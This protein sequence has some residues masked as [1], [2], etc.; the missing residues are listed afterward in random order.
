MTDDLLLEVEEKMAKAVDALRHDLLI[1]RTGRASP[2]LVEDLKVEAY[3]SVMPLNQL[4]T[5]A[6]PE[7]RL[8]VIRPWDASTLSAIERA[9]LKSDLGLT[10]NND[11]KVIRL[12]IPP[13]T[14]ERRKDLAR[15]VNQRVEE[16]RV[17]VRNARRD[18]MRALQAMER[19]GDISEDDRYRAQND[20]QEVTD[21]YIGKL[22]ALGEAKQKEIMEV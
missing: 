21:E 5:I 20:L 13:L 3:E 22:D 15:M 19:D 9:I 8:L 1:I 7:A 18:A 4:A 14:D 11:G 2:A 17:A 12:G 10:P 16:G 6:V